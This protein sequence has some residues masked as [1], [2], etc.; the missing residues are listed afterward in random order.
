MKRWLAIGIAIVV[1][2]LIATNVVLLFDEES[3]I[4]RTYYIKEYDRPTKSTYVKE[5]E[6]E[7]VIV[8]T[9]IT[10][11]S[12]EIEK[13]QH[14]LVS[15][16]DYVQ[17]EMELAQ[18]N[19]AYADEQRSLWE[20]QQQAYQRE[21]GQLLQLQSRLESERAS[22][23][24]TVSDSNTSTANNADG[25][26]DVNVQVDVSASQDGNFAQAIAQTELKLLEIERQLDIIRA[27]LNQPAGELAVVSPVEGTIGSIQESEGKY[28]IEVYTNDKSLVT[29][30]EENEWH[31]LG[32]GQ[33]VKSY[34]THLEG[35]LEGSVVSRS[36]V[37]VESSKWLTA[38][39]Q[40]DKP[41]D[42]PLYEIEVQF[43]Q[44]IDTLPFA[45]NVNSVFITNEAADAVRIPAKWLVA[46]EEEKA[47]IYTLTE[48][49]KIAIT[50]VTVPFHLDK[51]AIVTD[52][53]NDTVVIEGEKKYEDSK[54]FL[55][56]PSK[57][58]SW[59]SIKAVHWKDYLKYLTYK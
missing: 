42:K 41:Y 32:E 50:P 36:Q 17:P 51:Y 53:Q 5:L 48:E 28:V 31:E 19:N 43:A 27:Q 12:I 24:G 25:E 38:F 3:E 10:H 56:F 13:V 47:A 40:F 7:S 37:P 22:T 30:V 26:M 2:M 39:E 8:P 46:N 44:P 58:P 49:G 14:L 11:V 20:T 15:E 16:G 6:K 33:L 45:A 59:N 23:P 21:Q 57:L 29:F 54:T 52:F 18:L 1:S 9:E 4:D 55:P 35:I 34:T